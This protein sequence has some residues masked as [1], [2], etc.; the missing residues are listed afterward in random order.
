MYTLYFYKFILG[1]YDFNIFI[2][3]TK[4]ALILYLFVLDIIRSVYYM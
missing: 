1:I 3:S 2:I 4:C